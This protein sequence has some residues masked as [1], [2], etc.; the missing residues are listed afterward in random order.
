MKILIQ[1]I[2]YAEKEIQL[3]FYASFEED[4]STQ[5]VKMDENE[6]I[7]IT[8]HISG[9]INVSRQKA[10]GELAAIWFNNQCE[11]EQWNE[12]VNHVKQYTRKL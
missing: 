1:S 5:Y 9:T 11:P 2:E 8:I 6:F 10:R 7:N 3:P 12:A 4:Y